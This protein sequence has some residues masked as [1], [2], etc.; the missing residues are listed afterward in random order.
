M[1]SQFSIIK[2][3]LLIGL[4][5]YWIIGLL[6]QQAAADTISND[7]YQIDI[8]QFDVA[9][10]AEHKLPTPTLQPVQNGNFGVASLPYSF[11]FSIEDP[12]LDFGSLTAT[13][14]VTRTTSLKISSPGSGY[15]VFAYQ[16]HTLLSKK[17]SSIPDTTCDNGACT[18]NTAS[19]WE[20]NLTYGF[21]FRCETQS[22]GTC[23]KGFEEADSF[24]QIPDRGKKEIPQPLMS[25]DSPVS[26]QQAKLTFKANIS[27]TQAKEAYVNTVTY[28]AVPNF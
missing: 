14:P 24:K 13:N 26:G 1:N 6:P 10:E 22:S 25:S 11:S 7:N 19:V 23:T 15:Q 27:G 3:P 16:D 4:L 28:I 9:P 18:E 8:E 20:N 2:N 12:F 21:G 5:V 17:N